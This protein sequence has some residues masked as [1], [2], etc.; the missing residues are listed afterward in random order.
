MPLKE[1]NYIT[2]KQGEGVKEDFMKEIAFKLD[3]DYKLYSDA[4]TKQYSRP[5]GRRG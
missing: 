1:R 4:K 2:F 5:K 3:S